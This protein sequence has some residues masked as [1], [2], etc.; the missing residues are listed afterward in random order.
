MLWEKRPAGRLYTG[1]RIH[2]YDSENS[3]DQEDHSIQI[4]FE[5]VCINERKEGV[6]GFVCFFIYLCFLR[7]SATTAMMTAIAM[8]AIPRLSSLSLR[9]HLKCIVFSRR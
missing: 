5:H 4:L 3:Q 9:S 7:N 2:R 8:A 1:F 6:C